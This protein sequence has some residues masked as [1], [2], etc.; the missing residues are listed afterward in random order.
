MRRI[1]P[2]ATTFAVLASTAVSATQRSMQLPT[3]TEGRPGFAPPVM[4][5]PPAAPAGRTGWSEE[6]APTRDPVPT[7]LGVAQPEK[8]PV[9]KDKGAP[10]ERSTHGRLSSTS[11]RSPV[12]AKTELPMAG[13]GDTTALPG[14][15]EVKKGAPSNVPADV[16]SASVAAAPSVTMQEKPADAAAVPAK[17]EPAAEKKVRDVVATPVPSPQAVEHAKASVDEARE[18]KK[19]AVT[20]EPPAQKEAAIRDTTPKEPVK[21]APA[22]AHF[23]GQQGRAKPIA[24]AGLRG[25]DSGNGDRLTLTRQFG[26]WALHCD[27]QISRNERICMIQQTLRSGE[28]D[29]FAWRLAT[30]AA[31]KP[32]VVFEFTDR[33][34]AEKGLGISIAGFDKTI[35]AEEWACNAGRC[36]A[37]MAIVGPVSSWF[38]NSSQ[39]QFRYDRGAEAVKI[40][41]PMS[42][43]EAAVQAL[44]NPLGLKTQVA[45]VPTTQVAKTAEAN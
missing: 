12:P 21:P 20:K 11:E 43:F 23:V 19:V 7:T 14:Q 25:D 6:P 17:V 15:K 40:S 9:L 30:S 24:L 1:I 22:K 42:G 13:K 4:F 38:T 45:G 27:M 29:A 35:P 44:Q 37:T 3:G 16:S 5:D 39:I 8:T 31:G 36:T 10:P 32:I 18:D 28:A 2:I 33:A 26:S 34:E 41:A